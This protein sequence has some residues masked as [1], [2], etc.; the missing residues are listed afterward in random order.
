MRFRKASEIEIKSKDLLKEVSKCKPE[1][2]EGLLRQIET[3]IEQSESKEGD[4]LSKN[5]DNKS[6]GIDEKQKCLVHNLNSKL[7]IPY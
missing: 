5:H 3:K 7:D 4:L 1:E 2:L 6:N